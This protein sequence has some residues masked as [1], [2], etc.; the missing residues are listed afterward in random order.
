MGKGYPTP[1]DFALAPTDA[2]INKSTLTKTKVMTN[3][4]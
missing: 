1:L 2:G 3:Q 4:I